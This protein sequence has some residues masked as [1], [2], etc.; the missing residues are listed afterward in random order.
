M[1]DEEVMKENL[2][3]KLSSLKAAGFK[4]LMDLTGVDFLY[5]TPRTKVLYFLHDPETYAR[6]VIY[7]YVPRGGSLPSATG[8]WEGANWYERELFDLF[9]V[10]FESHPHLTRILMPDDWVGHPLQKDFPLMEEPVQFKHDRNPKIPSEIISYV[11]RDQ[12]Q[13]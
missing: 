8:L 2:I 11:E 7:T 13:L 6:S 1:I 12:R 10:H 4:V 5:P 9:G 3:E